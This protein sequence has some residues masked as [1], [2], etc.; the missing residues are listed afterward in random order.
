MAILGP[1]ESCGEEEVFL[2]KKR[3]VSAICASESAKIFAIDLVVRRYAPAYYT[4][5]PLRFIS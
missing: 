3:Q 2:N 4:V 5:I 1:K